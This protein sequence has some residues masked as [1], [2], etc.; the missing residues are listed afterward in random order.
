MS[1]NAVHDLIVHGKV[2]LFGVKDSFRIAAK[3]RRDSRESPARARSAIT[4]FHE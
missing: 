3:A 2:D 4:V 1:Y